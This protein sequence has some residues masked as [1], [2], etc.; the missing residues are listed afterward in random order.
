MNL[1]LISLASVKTQLGIASGTTTYDASITAMLPIVSSDIR[2]ILNCGYDKYIAA[3]FSNADATLSIYNS[4][5]YNQFVNTTYDNLELGQV[6][7][8]TSI[9]D[10]TYLKSY[11]PDTGKYTLSA[12]PTGTGSYV[13]PSIKLSMFPTIAKMIWYKFSKQ[14]MTSSIAKGISSESY[15]PVSISYSDKEINKRY[16][17]PQV[18]IDDLGTP[19]AKIG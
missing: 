15:G 1:N 2:R 7:Y 11:N 5:T 12:T 10:D 3:T 13:Y 6:V 17:Y 8:H 14:N 16:D 4:M 19:Y 18:L 9:P